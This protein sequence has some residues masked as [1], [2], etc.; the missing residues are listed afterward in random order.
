[1][2]RFNIKHFLSGVGISIMNIRRLIDRLIIIMQTPLLI[3]GCLYIA[4]LNSPSY[5]FFS[6]LAL[7]IN[8]IRGCFVRI[9]LCH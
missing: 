3:K 1:M 9:G 8:A 6:Y 7:M 5:G 4:I 2:R